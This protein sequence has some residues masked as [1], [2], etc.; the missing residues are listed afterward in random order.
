MSKLNKEQMLARVAALDEAADHLEQEWTDKKAE[1]EQGQ[2][3]SK[4]LR[5]Q[6]ERLY[7][8]YM[9]LVALKGGQG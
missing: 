7:V 9:Q 8:K 3:V 4:N 1:R 5:R 2:C 6:A